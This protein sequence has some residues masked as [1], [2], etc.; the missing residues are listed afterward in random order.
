MEEIINILNNNKDL[1]KINSK[2]LSEVVTTLGGI[3]KLDYNL[4]YGEQGFDELDMVEVVMNLE[5]ALDISIPDEVAMILFETNSKPT[6][7]TKWYRDKKLEELG[8][9]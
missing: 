4:T 3:D 6:D 1:S 2:V 5:R 9:T 8:I 7:L